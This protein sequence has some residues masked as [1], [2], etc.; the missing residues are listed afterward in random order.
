MENLLSEPSIIIA[1]IAFVGGLPAVLSQQR[2]ARDKMTEERVAKILEQQDADIEGLKKSQ[3]RLKT[4]V[5]ELRAENAHVWEMF[6]MAVDAFSEH[7]RW[8]RAGRKW[9]EPS[10][11]KQLKDYFPDHL[12]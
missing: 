2:T 12:L 6:T 11:P 5:K 7:L 10:I 4:E 8:D 1:L 9:K 3:L